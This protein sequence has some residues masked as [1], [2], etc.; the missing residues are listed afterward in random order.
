MGRERRTIDP[1]AI[2]H[3]VSTGSA[4]GAIVRDERDC[5]SLLADLAR[6][7]ARYAWEVFAWCVMT[8]HY[9]VVLRTSA[10]GFSAGFQLLNGSHSRRTNRRYKQAAH[11]FKNRPY[12]AEIRTDAHLATAVLYVVRNPLAAGMCEHAS[13]W[14]FSSYRAS[15][16][17]AEPPPWLSVGTLRS[18]FG[19]AAEFERLVHSGHLPV[20]DTGN[21]TASPG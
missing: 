18:L 13:R 6:A 7:A 11:L 15:V 20:S 16:G 4:G 9:H 12:A 8:T 19:G 17:L 5:N 14:A 10:D 2:Y 1:E 21:G 3:V